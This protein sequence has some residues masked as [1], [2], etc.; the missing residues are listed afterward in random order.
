M[1]I[2]CSHDGGIP[3]PTSSELNERRRLAT[4]TTADLR[5]KQLLNNIGNI[6][7]SKRGGCLLDGPGKNY[8]KDERIILPGNGS[9]PKIPTGEGGNVLEELVNKVKLWLETMY[10]EGNFLEIENFYQGYHL[11]RE[12]HLGR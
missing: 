1:G 7:I 11:L 2:F 8:H 10:D 6:G 9:G 3:E 12:K 4:K 5:I